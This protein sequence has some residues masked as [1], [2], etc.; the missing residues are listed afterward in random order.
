MPQ[1]A[2]EIDHY[3]LQGIIDGDLE[4][5]KFVIA[6]GANIHCVN[7]FGETPIIIATKNGHRDIVQYLLENRAN[8][9]AQ[10]PN[11]RIACDYTNDTEILMLL[12]T[13]E[14]KKVPLP[15]E[16]ETDEETQD[17]EHAN[18]AM[19]SILFNPQ[20]QLIDDEEL[21]GQEA[22]ISPENSYILVE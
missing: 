18:D 2:Q 17:D 4:Y 21:T 10:D 5:I 20:D 1:E 13:Y 7:Q 19:Q 3:L 22:F 11:G 16:S 12:R 15:D 14:A 9:L 6:K 8:T